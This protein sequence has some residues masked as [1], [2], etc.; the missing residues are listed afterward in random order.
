MKM[1]ETHSRIFGSSANFR[2]EQLETENTRYPEPFRLL[3]VGDD[4]SHGCGW[5]S[6]PPDYTFSNCTTVDEGFRLQAIRAVRQSTNR[7]VVTVGSKRNPPQ[8]PED[9]SRHESWPGLRIDEISA[10]VDWASFSAD[11]ILIYTGTTDIIQLDSAVHMIERFEAML[12]RVH[13][14]L[15]TSRVIVCTILDQGGLTTPEMRY[16]LGAFNRLLPA[17]VSRRRASMME[18][19]LADV[20]SALPKLCGPGSGVVEAGRAPMCSTSEVN[21]TSA[22]YAQVASALKP[23]LLEVFALDGSCRG[24]PLCQDADVKL[25]RNQMDGGLRVVSSYS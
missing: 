25:W 3:F 5:K 13:A 20:A 6:L 10:T 16:N 23:A 4:H 14:A 8:A 21:P 15:P 24:L 18:I 9:S 11:V 2:N 12:V 1:F 22:G 7:K 19:Y 17:V